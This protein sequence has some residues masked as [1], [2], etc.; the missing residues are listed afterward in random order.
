MTTSGGPRNA[1]ESI[2]ATWSGVIAGMLS[3]AG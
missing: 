1:P 2:G 3:V